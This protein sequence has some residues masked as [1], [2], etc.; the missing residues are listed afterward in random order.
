VASNQLLMPLAEYLAFL[1][2]AE[3]LGVHPML[4]FI[5]HLE[6]IMICRNLL[7]P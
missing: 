3:N 4:H 7:A 2:A 1:V 5:E 6:R